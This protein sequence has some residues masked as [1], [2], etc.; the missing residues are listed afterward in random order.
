MEIKDESESPASDMEDISD[1]NINKQDNKM[2]KE[3]KRDSNGRAGSGS[4]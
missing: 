3:E 4:Q 2:Q 1:T